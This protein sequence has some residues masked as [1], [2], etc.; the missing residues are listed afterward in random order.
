MSLKSS[1]TWRQYM[2]GKY[3]Y[4]LQTVQKIFIGI[5]TA[6]IYTV[7]YFFWKRM[8]LMLDTCAYYPG[9]RLISGHDDTRMVVLEHRGK[10]HPDYEHCK[11]LVAYKK[12]KSK[13]S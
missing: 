3:R 1:L 2:Y 7:A 11:Y 5:I 12:V 8:E 13:T 9:D 4:F 6:V 10:V